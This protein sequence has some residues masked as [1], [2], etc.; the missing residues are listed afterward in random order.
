MSSVAPLGQLLPALDDLSALRPSIMKYAVPEYSKKEVNRVGVILATYDPQ[1]GDFHAYYKALSV[2]NN[3]RSSHH[4]PL[5]TFQIGLRKKATL[6]DQN[7]VVAQRI[8]R[9]S[10]IQIKLQRFPTMTLSQ[11]QDI[12][13]C[14]A[15]LN[16]VDDVTQLVKSYDASDLKH[17]KHAH[18][19]YI[20][21]PKSSGYRG[22]HIVWSYNSDRKTTYN[23]LKIE[24]QLRSQIQHAWATAVETVGTFVSQA[25]KSSQG[26]DNWLR[27]FALMGTAFAIREGTPPV[28]GTPNLDELIAELR[29][30]VNNL[31]IPRRL[32]AYGATLGVLEDP[33]VGDAHYFLLELQPS[34][35]TIKVT[36]FRA[37][38]SEK[39]SEAYLGAEKNIAP[40]S[41]AEAV[42]V[43]VD[44]IA[45]LRRAYPN[46]FLDTN[47]FI[48]LVEETII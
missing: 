46:Y 30:H 32:R 44:S 4:F 11:M 9:L 34:D 14:R 5:N 2:I 13:G 24:M 29:V 36:G 15:I 16:S 35:D 22:V 12:G 31:D 1:H 48:N 18:D 25:L 7:C 8:K 23:S 17:K 43:S 6:I 19:D 47:N 37:N 33:D 10:S 20:I 26:E 45:A 21:N 42:L 41:G 38:E 3:W 40:G 28:P 27:F 39:A